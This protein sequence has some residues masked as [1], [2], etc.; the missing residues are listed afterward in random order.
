M[1][2]LDIAP[3]VTAVDLESGWGFR[4][5]LHGGYLL[6]VITETALRSVDPTVHP[7]PVSV[8]ASYAGAPLRG[9][10][11][12]V[13]RRVKTGRTFATLHASLQQEG[14]PKVEVLVTAGR[15]PALDEPAQWDAQAEP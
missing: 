2:T 9:P 14:Q 11:E 7:H 4:N 15:L 3:D 5:R 12:I 10:A 8:Q 6:A 13:V 1:S